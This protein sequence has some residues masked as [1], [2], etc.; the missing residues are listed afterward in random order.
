VADP[1]NWE[2]F[3]PANTGSV[4]THDL[5][6]SGREVIELTLSLTLATL[7]GRS[8]TGSPEPKVRAVSADKMLTFKQQSRA[9][10][11]PRTRL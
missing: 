6:V 11:D 10:G 1:L 4:P 5:W 2:M 8:P 3:S 9:R 7:R